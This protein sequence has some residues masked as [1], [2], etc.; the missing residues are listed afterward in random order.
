MPRWGVPKD[1]GSEGYQISK[2]QHAKGVSAMSKRRRVRSMMYTQQTDHMSLTIEALERILGRLK[3]VKWALIVHDHDIDSD[4]KSIPTHIHLMMVFQNAREIPAIAKQL[5][6]KPQYIED[7]SKFGTDRGERNGFAYLLHATIGARK[8]YQYDVSDVRANF[9][10]AALIA[11][12]QANNTPSIRSKYQQ[13][14]DRLQAGD[15]NQGEAQAAVKLACGTEYLAT[16]LRQ[17]NDIYQLY[18]EADAKRWREQ[19]EKSKEPIRTIWLYGPAGQ[20]KGILAKTILGRMVGDSI[21]TSSADNDPLQGYQGERGLILEELRPGYLTYREVLQML[22]PFSYV[23]MTHARY[24]NRP[25]KAD[26]IVITTPLPPDEYYCAVMRRRSVSDSQRD[27]FRQLERRC[28]LVVQVTENELR[29]MDYNWKKLS[30][31]CTSAK[32][33]IYLPQNRGYV[34]KLTLND[35]LDK[36]G[37]EHFG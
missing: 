23:S 3:A 6:D 11:K 29:T 4:G 5:R 27:G 18:L 10:Y 2:T 17:I 30:Y 19:K 21:Y 14:L 37:D 16:H 15:I 34:Q 7:F 33:N 9:D 31:E 8:K 24:H 13:I 22:D 12:L 25:L 1:Y 32:P 36:N 28:P 20:G 26:A 35:I